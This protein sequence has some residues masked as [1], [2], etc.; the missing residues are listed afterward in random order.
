MSEGMIY[1]FLIA[2][3]LMLGIGYR[4]RNFEWKGKT[5][6]WVPGMFTIGLVLVVMTLFRGWVI[7]VFRIPTASMVPAVAEGE[8]VGVR[9]YQK[10]PNSGD[11]I[12]FHPPQDNA[13]WLKRVVGVAGDRV[14]MR[15][16]E[17]FINGESTRVKGAAPVSSGQ[18]VEYIEK[19]GDSRFVARY[20]TPGSETD[21][22]MYKQDIDTRVPE[23]Y[24][25]VL[26]DNRNTSFDSRE[27]GP[28]KL[29]RIKGMAMLPKDSVSE[30]D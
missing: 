10:T 25:Y 23:G 15:A 12:Y 4:L 13:M 29:D 7:D 1:G 5:P 8:F 18:S 22:A 26:G 27:F 16:G 20:A 17:L 9:R 21:G 14:E 30:N 19:V 11:V 2:G 24:V 6:G 3:I 28:V